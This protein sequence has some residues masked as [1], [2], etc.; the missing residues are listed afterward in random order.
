[1]EINQT[2]Q[3]WQGL[4]LQI[5]E[6]AELRGISQIQIAERT[7]MVQTNISRIFLLKYC[8]NLKTI[9]AIAE[10]VGVSLTLN[11]EIPCE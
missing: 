7:G 5:K 9:T 3:H 10:A 4:V 8:P 6:A 1:M 2:D 11:T